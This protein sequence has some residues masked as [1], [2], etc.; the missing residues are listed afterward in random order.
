MSDIFEPTDTPETN[1]PEP[2]SEAV[3]ELVFNVEDGSC[4][5][6][7]NSYISLEE[8][9]QYQTNKG[10]TDWLSLSEEDKKI[11]LIKG[12]Q[13]VN[14]L[15]NWKGRRK[16]EVQT[17]AFPRVNIFDNDGFEVKDIPKKLKEAV[18]EAAFYSFQEKKEL[19]TVYES[20]TGK[21]KRD[22]KVVSGAVEKE[23]E[24]FAD[25]EATVEYISKYASLNSLLKGLYLEKDRPV[26]ICAKVRWDGYDGKRYW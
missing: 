1:L 12:T 15:Y 24:F 13:Y 26:G 19:F 20:E 8:A 9:N 16:Y 4:V 22:K 5:T 3:I 18:C 17:L 21:V 7:A 10:R 2:P 25:S 14:E 23:I 6:D 11:T